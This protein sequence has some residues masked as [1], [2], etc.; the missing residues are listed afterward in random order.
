MRVV[1]GEK[2]PT[3]RAREL[4]RWIA[5]FPNAVVMRVAGAGHFVAEEAP[6]TV[7]EAVR[8]IG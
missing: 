7:V 8:A 5:A 3:F 1:W 4:E 6:G 2:D